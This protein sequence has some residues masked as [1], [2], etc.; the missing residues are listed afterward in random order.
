[1]GW[2]CDEELLF[3][4]LCEAKLIVS[5]SLAAPQSSDGDVSPV[6]M[7]KATC[8]GLAMVT[9]FGHGWPMSGRVSSLYEPQSG[10]GAD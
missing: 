4:E 10:T 3:G 9:F 5:V 7:M 2:H 1:M 6:R 8:A